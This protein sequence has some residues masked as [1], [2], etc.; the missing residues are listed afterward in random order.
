MMFPRPYHGQHTVKTSQRHL[1]NLLMRIALAPTVFDFS[2]AS[3]SARESSF[4]VLFGY[5]LVS[6]TN[7]MTTDFTDATDKK[8]AVYHPW[9]P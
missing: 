4:Y 1:K 3:A 9:H 2:A 6:L 7:K 8:S 5:R